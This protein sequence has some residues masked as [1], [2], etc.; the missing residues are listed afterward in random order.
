MMS[1][2][3]K[4]LM[5]ENVAELKIYI[6]C[7]SDH[8]KAGRPQLYKALRQSMYD[9]WKANSDLS[10]DRRQCINIDRSKM[11]T[12]TKDLDD[13][14]IIMMEKRKNRVVAQKYIYS[15]SGVD[16]LLYS[17]SKIAGFYSTLEKSGPIQARTQKKKFCFPKKIY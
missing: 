11:I 1:Q 9:A 2:I 17:R 4:D 15:K 13:S 12:A 10:T 3:A 14:D 6:F 5:F 16:I 7:E 8:K